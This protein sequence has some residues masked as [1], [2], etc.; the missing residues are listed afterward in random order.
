[1]KRLYRL[2]LAVMLSLASLAGPARLAHAQP[3]TGTADEAEVS[4]QLGNAA[5]A[6]GN[7]R[8]ALGYYFASN[9]LA[10]NRNVVFNLAYCYERLGELVE[11]Y[12]YYQE[13]LHASPADDPTAQQS[14]DALARIGPQVGV[15][16]VD[17]D[18][19]GAE[20]YLD[21]ID[22]GA[23]ATTPALI[24]VKPGTYTVLVR[25]DGSLP[26]DAPPLTVKPGD[27]PHISARMKPITGTLTVNGGPQGSVATV[28]VGGVARV[29]GPVPG[30]LTVP[31]GRHRLHVEH[32]GYASLEI[33]VVIAEGQDRQ[34]QVDLAPETGTLLVS[35]DELGAL[36]RVDG[37]PAGFT[38]AVLDRVGVG[39]HHLEVVAEGF[40]TYAKDV[41]VPNQGRVEVHADLRA[42][43]DIEAA[44]LAR[45][46]TDDAPAS[47]SLISSYEMR[48]L[49]YVDLGDALTGGRGTYVTNDYDYPVAGFRGF[50]PLGD[51]GNRV[52][53]QLDGHTMNYLY[54]GSSHITA[55]GLVGLEG[56]DRIEIVRGP[57]STLYGSGAMFGV[58]NLVPPRTLAEPRGR[59]GFGAAGAES[60]R[61]WADY[62]RPFR[63][64]DQEGSAWAWGTLAYTQPHAYRSPSRVGS[65]EFPDGTTEGGE[66]LAGSTMGRVVLG[67]LSLMWFLNS[68]DN[69]AVT[70]PFGSYF[71]NRDIVIFDRRG[72]AE[73]RWQPHLSKTVDLDW[74]VALDHSYYRGDYPRDAESDVLYREVFHAWALDSEA[75]VVVTP[76]GWPRLTFGARLQWDIA[77]TMKG[78]D[79]GTGEFPLD[80]EHPVID[81]AAF[82]LADW[83]V[84]ERVALHLG[85][86][87]D[88]RTVLA[89]TGE[90]ESDE[91][92]TGTDGAVSPRAALVWRP[93]DST[94]L[95]VM[96]GA[97]FRAPSFYEVAYND[98]GVTQVSPE[99]LTAEKIY[100]LETELS[101]HLSDNLVVRADL[102]ASS[103]SNRVVLNGDGTSE[104]PL[105]YA[106]GGEAVSTAG[107]ELEIVHEL[108]R[109]LTYSFSYS[110]QRARLGGLFD[111]SAAENSPTHLFGGKAIIPLAAEALSLVS[112]VAIES[113]RLDLDGKYTGA[114]VLL[115]IGFAGHIRAINGD[116]HLSVRNALDWAIDHPGS[117]LVADTRVRQPGLSFVGEVSL[118]F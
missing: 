3:R 31:I 113:G 103:L 86:R 32:P 95:K 66:M 19:P 12:R 76:D 44:S 9:R 53:V 43:S 26:F 7:F 17:S 116:Y 59:V 92:Y 75:R 114:T 4:F 38:P 18:P 94:I 61:A 115:D 1:M 91:A 10:P 22:L 34:V 27:N 90:G 54:D 41:E 28:L 24:P 21:R 110:L 101:Q 71:G 100:T 112:R 81:Y 15:I 63:V 13:H 93:T 65:E 78:G 42:A 64:G 49:G 40:G 82:A 107:L 57:G 23:Y 106:N 104:S 62:G 51:F 70:A 111:G 50:A 25:A 73:L 46:S 80:E 33:D 102:Y 96:A 67:D 117:G 77:D 69:A 83:S 79:V 20:V 37:Q 74:R 8:E 105:Q 89:E 29:R 85:L 36:I 88:A 45:E 97:A 84:S 14:R 108:E 56:L 98:G 68:R 118:V 11:A 6:A 58:V 2:A 109:G 30:T 39:K 52:Q 60:A 5:F 48:L 35:C 55:D 16:A 47:V 72:F 99:H 87:A